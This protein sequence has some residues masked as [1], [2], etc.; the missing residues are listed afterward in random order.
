MFTPLY[1][2]T[3]LPSKDGKGPNPKN[4]SI[5]AGAYLMLFATCSLSDLRLS[6]VLL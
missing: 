1:L 6:F 3:K 2:I 4:D 5:R